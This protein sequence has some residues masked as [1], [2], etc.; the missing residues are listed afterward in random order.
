MTFRQQPEPSDAAESAGAAA[1]P[2]GEAEAWSEV[3]A[4]WS[5][6]EAHR[7]Y[8]ARFG[9]LEGLAQAGRRYREVLAV[10]PEDAVAR[11]WRDEILKRATVQGLAQLPRTPPPRRV[12]PGARRALLLAV[13]LASALAAAW[14]VRGLLGLG[15]AR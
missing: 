3:L 5:D 9:D 10:R 13:V 2:G 4:R 14:V 12:G 1:P 15:A 7:G 6:D 11:R 8:L